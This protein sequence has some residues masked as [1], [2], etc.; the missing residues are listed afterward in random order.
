LVSDIAFKAEGE[1]R[2]GYETQEIVGSGGV[3]PGAVPVH[4][5][6]D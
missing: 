2:Y 4:N 3:E 1:F 6:Q 5:E